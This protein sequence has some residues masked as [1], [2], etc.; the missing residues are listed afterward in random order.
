MKRT[1]KH[2]KSRKYRYSWFILTFVI[3]V[4]LIVLR[5]P[6]IR[7]SPELSEDITVNRVIDG[8]TI[9]LSDG[10]TVRMIGVDTPESVHPDQSRNSREGKTASEWTHNLLSGEKVRLEYDK[11]RTDKY[12]RTLAYV[13]Y[14]DEMV[15][16]MLLKKGF[17]K[18]MIIEPNIKYADRFKRLEKQAKQDKAGFWKDNAD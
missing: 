7:D 16:E 9:E 8:D 18:T 12:G 6:Y 11:E 10:T 17:A 3:A 13:Y 14:K 5:I 2:K 15:N 1:Y 4:L